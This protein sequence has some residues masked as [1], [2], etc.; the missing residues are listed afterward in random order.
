MDED[1]LLR[2]ALWVTACSVCAV[3]VGCGLWPYPVVRGTELEAMMAVG[4][5]SFLSIGVWLLAVCAFVVWRAESSHPRT[6]STAMVSFVMAGVELP[7]RVEGLGGAFPA[8]NLFLPCVLCC[9]LL[10]PCHPLFLC[11]CVEWP[12]AHGPC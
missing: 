5:F 12:H 1:P 4:L 11:S 9:F 8:R 7:A 2:V 10:F 6:G 3:F